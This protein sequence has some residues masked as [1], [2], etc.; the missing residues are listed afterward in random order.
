MQSLPPPPF[1]ITGFERGSLWRGATVDVWVNAQALWSSCA[2]ALAL[3]AARAC[4]RAH[5]RVHA[6]ACLH[7]RSAALARARPL[8]SVWLCG[9][10]T[11]L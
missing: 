11:T 10:V 3:R 6:C 2:H 4:A 1:A 8:P 5:A 7:A 9:C